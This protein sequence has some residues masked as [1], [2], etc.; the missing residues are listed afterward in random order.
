MTMRI[1]VAGLL[2]ILSTAALAKDRVTYVLDWLPTGKNAPFYVAQRE[3]FFADEDLDVTILSGRGAADVVTRLATGTSEFGG[4]GISSLM[5]AVANAAPQSPI[6]VKAIYSI[7]TKQ[8]DAVLTVKGNGILTLKDLAGRKVATSPFTSSNDVLPILAADNGLDL[9][10]VALMKA[11]GNSLTSLLASGGADAVINWVMSGPVTE[12]ALAST[13]R[14]VQVLPWSEFGLD[15]YSLSI[16]ASDKIIRE[17]PDVVRRFLRA[18]NK[19]IIFSVAD[20]AA[21]ARD[22][23]AS[24]PAGDASMAKAEFE[25]SIPLIRNDISAA[26]GMG[27]LKPALLHKTWMWVARSQ[28]F[29]ADRIDPEKIVDG[30]F[31]PSR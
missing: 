24:V 17:Q 13:G 2:A 25:A 21:A 23:M 20:P 14:N 10:K 22:F 15:G 31:I 7:Y 12:S 6:A 28:K 8:P 27:A 11:D 18:V 16:F 19:A 29:P 1:A 30:S 5:S 4:G 3:G 9:Q 26:D